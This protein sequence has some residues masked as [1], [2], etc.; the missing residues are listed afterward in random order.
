MRAEHFFGFIGS[1]AV[2]VAFEGIFS[3]GYSFALLCGA[4]SLFVCLIPRER[5]YSKNVFLV[6]LILLGCALGSLRVDVSQ[7]T[8]SHAFD[9]VIEKTVNIEGIIIDEPDVREEYTN[10]VLEVKRISNVLYGGQRILVRVPTYPELH[11]GD[12]VSLIGKITK[13]KNFAPKENSKLFDYVSY[14]AK[15]DIYYQMYFPDVLITGSGKGNTIREK[16]FNLKSWFIKNISQSIPE[17]EASLASGITFGAKQSLG[18]DLLKKF[19]ETGVAH[20]VVLSG[21]NIAVVAGII[22]RLVVFMPFSIRLFMSALGIVLFAVMVGSGTTVV[23]ATI[24]ALVVILARVLGREGDALRALFLAG[25][26][27]V[28]V[29]PMVLLHDVSFQLSFSATFALVI[30]VPV[31]EK[32]FLFIANRIFRE[33]IVTTIATQ[34]FVFPLIIY[35]MGSVSLI[36]FIAN[37]FILPVIPLA[38]IAVGLLAIFS[39]IPLAGSA[40]AVAAHFLLTYVVLA[41]ETFS[42]VPLASLQ[43]VSFPLW[44]LLFS[45]VLMGFFIIKNTSQK[46]HIDRTRN[47]L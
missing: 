17:P 4:L 3:F 12:E 2:G 28:L 21:Y 11:Y 16:L 45:Y 39:W 20:I 40:L 29:N 42:R 46:T 31:V 47:Y 8:H 44:G 5:P 38:M 24:M 6:S 22:S 19:R 9:S 41:V 23:R 26:L 35:H 25:G 7:N 43:G 10:I 1:F 33:I 27:M 14:L 18:E 37:I 34:I 32:Y 15:D 13:P 30:L 36:G